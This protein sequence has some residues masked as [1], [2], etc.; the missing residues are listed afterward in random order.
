MELHWTVLGRQC[1]TRFH[2]ESEARD[3]AA[4]VVTREWVRDVQLLDED[5]EIVEAS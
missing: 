5:G 3:W 2:S 4:V 1:V